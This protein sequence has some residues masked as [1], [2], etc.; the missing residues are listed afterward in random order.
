MRLKNNKKGFTLIELLAVIVIL[1]IIALIATPII[2]NVI[3][4]AKKS[5]AIDSAYG[6][7]EAIEYQNQMNTLDSE[8]YPKIESGNVT[9]LNSSV[10]VK[11]TKPDSGIVAIANNKVVSAELCINGYKAVYQNNKVEIASDS[12]ECRTGSNSNNSQQD[13]NQQ[14]NN[15]QNNNQQNNNS[16]EESPSCTNVTVDNPS[17]YD[18]LIGSK[19]T[20]TDDSEWFVIKNS[21]KNDTT[22]RLMSTKNIKNNVSTSLTGA[23]LFSNVMSEYA[24]PYTTSK[25]QVYSNV[26][27]TPYEGSNL[28][29]YIKGSVKTAIE[30]SLNTTLSYIDIWNLDDLQAVGVTVEY[31]SNNN[32]ISNLVYDKSTCWFNE[33]FRA[34]H[35]WT[36]VKYQDSKTHVFVNQMGSSYTT[37]PDDNMHNGAKP[38]IVVSKSLIKSS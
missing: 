13:N 16:Q 36:N 23:D 24:I 34:A 26:D 4:R 14:N 10:N 30:N 5:A 1:A 6:Y 11:G 7:I 32:Y 25:V 2:L 9:S 37:N 12:S 38:V 35:M 31:M 3:S 18:Y 21:K 8:K 28:Q 15:Q 27:Y 29:T 22:I 33:M 19:V 17:E 20:L